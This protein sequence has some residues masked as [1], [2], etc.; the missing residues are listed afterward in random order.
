MSAADRM[1]RTRE[2]Q[3]RGRRVLRVEVDE[4]AVENMLRRYRYLDATADDLREIE[5]AIER[6]LE[7]LSGVTRNDVDS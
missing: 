1:R 4:A 3:A 7:H 2:R 5:T 6:L